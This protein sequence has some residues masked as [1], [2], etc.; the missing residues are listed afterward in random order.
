M[1]GTKSHL[2]F[3]LTWGGERKAAAVLSKSFDAGP[4]TRVEG[5]ASLTRRVH[6]FYEQ[7]ERRTRLWLR[8]ERALS[9]SLRVGV[10]ADR[11]HV[12]LGPADDEVPAIGAD[13]TLDTRVDPWLARNA[14]LVRASWRRAGFPAGG[15]NLT[16]LDAT[17]YIGL[18]GQPVLVVRARHRG[19][20]AHV[21]VYAQALLG[22]TD[23]LRG[24]RLGVA[25]G[26]ELAAGSLELRVPLSSPI[27]LVKVGVTT[28]VDVAAVYD[29][30]EHLRDQPFSQGVGV[31][32]WLSIAALR[33]TL[34]IAHGVG[35]ST[36]VQFGASLGI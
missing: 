17:G 4:V 33:V 31:G 36:R 30:G 32:A 20:D 34:S 35:A 26:D 11:Q 28:F 6:P 3:P 2:S 1:L 10:T 9:P 5:G 12:T 16:D 14:V 25:A 7:P 8:A 18:P 15:A 23:T 24:D 21:P 27:Q 22:G 29:K 19:A 13:L